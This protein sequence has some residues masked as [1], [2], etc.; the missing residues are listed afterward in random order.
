MISTFI[1]ELR[2]YSPVVETIVFSGN[3]IPLLSATY[4]I[5]GVMCV[6]EGSI[7]LLIFRKS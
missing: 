6:S 3:S 2:V 4:F 7:T 1:L 5:D